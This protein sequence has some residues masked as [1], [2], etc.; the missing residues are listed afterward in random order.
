MAWDEFGVERDPS[1]TLA[2]QAGT[3]RFYNIELLLML[4]AIA[5]TN[6]YTED[7]SAT[8]YLMGENPDKIRHGGG[9]FGVDPEF[10]RVRDGLVASGKIM[11]K[12]KIEQERKERKEGRR[13]RV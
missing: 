11:M 9:L 3:V 10:H 12:E 5:T 7:L 1:W 6:S 8:E 13:G 2:R 4:D